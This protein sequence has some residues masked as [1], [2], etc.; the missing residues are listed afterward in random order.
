MNPFLNQ[1]IVKSLPDGKYELS[2]GYIVT[3][4][5]TGE[6]TQKDDLGRLK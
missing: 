1:T 2:N 6:T 3:I 5:F 4:A